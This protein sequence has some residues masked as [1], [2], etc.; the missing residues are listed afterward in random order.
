MTFRSNLIS[1]LRLFSI[2]DGISYVVLL[3]IAMP[4]KYLADMPMAVRVVGSLHGFLWVGLC[5][6][7]LLTLIT[8]RLPFKWCVIV[9]ICALIPLVPFFLDRKL[10]AFGK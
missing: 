6:F 9:F 10:K 5:L 1:R 4:L 3:G 7:L 8:K 2:L